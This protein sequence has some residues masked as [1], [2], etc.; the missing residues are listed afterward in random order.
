MPDYLEDINNFEG[1]PELPLLF[2]EVSY[3]S[4][5]FGALLIDQLDLRPNLRILDVACGA[6]FPLFEMAHMFGPTCHLVGIDSWGAAVARARWKQGRFGL[7]N[8]EI[9]GGDAAAMP[10]DD[11]DFDLITCNL[12]LNNFDDAEAVFGECFRVAKPGASLRLTSNVTGNMREFYTI[13]REV[14][15][16]MGKKEAVLRLSA[17]ENHRRSR[18][19]I[20]GLLEALGFAIGDAVEDHFTLRYVDGTS[21][22]NHHLIKFGFLDGWRGVVEPGDQRLVFTAVER[23]LNEI[24]AEQGSL[25][26]TIPMLYLEATKPPGATPSP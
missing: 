7:P 10:F 1:D 19:A 22:F 23:R 17:Q 8:V 13:F 25:T 2:D 18:Q 21:F 15:T 20:S 16:G 12:G 11:G 5:R 14:L 4:S 9:L 24:A 3:W 6:G 26:M